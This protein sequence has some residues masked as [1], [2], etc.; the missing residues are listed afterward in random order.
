MTLGNFS[1]VTEGNSKCLRSTRF[2]NL[3]KCSWQNDFKSCTAN[4]PLYSTKET[5]SLDMYEKINTLGA[6]QGYMPRSLQKD[7]SVSQF[8]L[9]TCQREKQNKHTPIKGKSNAREHKEKHRSTRKAPCSVLAS[10]NLL[11]D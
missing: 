5:L 7:S 1:Q 11:Q 10:G 9:P 4:S 3:G 2:E 6:L 8:M